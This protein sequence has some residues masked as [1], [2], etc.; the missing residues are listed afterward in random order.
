MKRGLWK[1][2]FSVLAAV[3]VSLPLGASGESGLKPARIF[4]DHAVLQRNA[5]IPVWGV[6][7]PGAEISV[8]FAGQT[9]TTKADANGRWKVELDPM[10]ASTKGRTLTV[11]S[12]SG[13]V[14]EV[15]DVLVGDV[16][17][18]SG[19]SNMEWPVSRSM[20]AEREI[21]A[22]EHP[23]IRFI[24]IPHASSPKPLDELPRES[25]WV[26]CSPD[27]VSVCSAVAY[28]FARELLKDDPSVPIGLV[29][30]DWGGTPAESWTDLKTL[31]ARPD[32]Y[33]VILNRYDK[34]IPTMGKTKI[35]EAEKKAYEKALAEWK[36]ATGPSGFY[37]EPKLKPHELDNASPDLDDSKWDNTNLPGL[38]ESKGLDIDGV[39]WYRKTIDLPFVWQGKDLLLSLGPIDDHDR[40]FWNG[41]EI[42]SM[43]DTPDAWR[44]PRRYKVP[45]KL[46]KEG[47]NVIAVRVFDS[48]GGGGFSGNSKLMYITVEGPDKLK[49]SLAGAWRRKVVVA[50]PQKPIPPSQ[51]KRNMGWLPSGLFNAMIHPLIP[52]AFK[53]VI[54]YQGESNTNSSDRAQ[55][56]R[57]LFQDM[58]KSW[59]RAWG[60]D[61][62]PFY[63]V[64]LA[65]FK[66][67]QTTLIRRN[68]WAELRESQ[69]AAL[70]LP[71]TGMAVA[72]DIGAADSI[73]PKNKQEVG[74]RLAL[75]ARK[76]LRGREVVDSGPMFDSMRV[77]GAD[78]V[79]KFKNV[80]SGLKIGGGSE[81]LEGFAVAGADRKFHWADA[82][83]I[84]KDEIKISSLE[85]P[86]PVAVRYAWH[87]NPKGNLQGGTGLPA[88]PFRTDEW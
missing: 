1:G 3:V 37:P 28:F 62:F 29:E 87:I 78:I 61:D 27:T 35:S 68:I 4:R 49:K 46:V 19:Q 65:N 7:S 63:F 2:L 88:C 80:G 77:D 72:I 10:P 43:G 53:G 16:W 66:A 86:W 23:E 32:L 9:R 60:G 34:F 36:A 40:T 31:R 47:I 51:R 26:V 30:A 12:S 75:I 81:K 14:A 45:G 21:A 8:S 70:L 39:V 73:H 20:N 38:W 52:M 85:V 56:Y 55:Q 59:R 13:G 17:I 22:A 57:T 48:F 50:L 64:Q 41:V 69:T 79:V 44:T 83:I 25:R 82:K 42:G 15:K 71:N 6:D 84:S 76:R 18:C 67:R 24:D 33:K 5:R 58:I 11:K 74:R 54:W